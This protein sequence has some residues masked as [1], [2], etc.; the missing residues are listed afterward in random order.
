MMWG[1]GHPRG[2]HQPCAFLEFRGL[3]STA[4]PPITG[5]FKVIMLH[6]HHC[7]R[8]RGPITVGPKV[9]GRG[10][11]S[12][13]FLW[14]RSSPAEIHASCG[15]PLIT[16]CRQYTSYYPCGNPQK[17]SRRLNEKGP[18]HNSLYSYRRTH[19]TARVRQPA[20]R[21]HSRVFMDA[22]CTSSAPSRAESPS[23]AGPAPASSAPALQPSDFSCGICYELLLDPVV[24]EF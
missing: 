23:Q 2:C 10:H 17:C 7:K 21:H 5:A 8:P 16:C 3:N 20:E 22:E 11:W 19:L 1:S 24:G 12:E 4:R 14:R 6:L 15:C 13:G 9:C 18:T